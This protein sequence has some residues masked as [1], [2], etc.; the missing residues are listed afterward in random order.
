M[1][2]ETAIRHDLVGSPALAGVAWKDFIVTAHVTAIRVIVTTTRAMMIDV[3]VTVTV[4]AMA[5]MMVAVALHVVVLVVPGVVPGN[6]STSSMCLDRGCRAG[7]KKYC[8]QVSQNF[9]GFDRR[10]PSRVAT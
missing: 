7:D 4:H 9:P 6:A 1:R 10:P 2:S 8:A 3:I 5:T